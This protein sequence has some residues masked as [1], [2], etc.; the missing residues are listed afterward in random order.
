MHE[1][2]VEK[3]VKRKMRSSD[4]VLIILMIL[5]GLSLTLVLF[6]LP[7]ML[8]PQL[9]IVSIIATPVIIYLLYRMISG[10]SKEYEYSFTNDLLTVDRIVA[11]KRRKTLFT[12]SCKDFTFAAPMVD[13][14]FDRYVGEKCLHLD[15]RSGSFSD[16]DWFIMT[17]SGGSTMMILIELDDRMV[18]VMR[19]YNPRAVKRIMVPKAENTGTDLGN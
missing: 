19:R 8:E 4:I 17:K 18:Q 13:D 1:M 6:L 2:F 9:F 5:S 12:G 15:V 11:K 14:D 16:D 10:I 3:I 7:L